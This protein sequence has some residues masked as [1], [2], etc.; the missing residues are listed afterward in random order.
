MQNLMMM[1]ALKAAALLGVLT[2][3]GAVQA[4]PLLKSV[5]GGQG[6]LDTST[7]LEWLQDWNLAGE[8][9]SWSESIA[10]IAKLNADKYAGHND[11]RLPNT[12]ASASSN[13]SL[14]S[15]DPGVGQLYYGYG[16]TGSE[17]GHLFYNVLGGKSDESI[18]TQAGDTADEIANLALFKNVQSHVYWSG[19]EYA[20]GSS[21]A[22][23]FLTYDGRQHVGVK[24]N[25]VYALAV[26][27]GGVTAAVPEPQTWALLL[28]GFTGLLLARR[29][30]AL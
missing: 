23:D 19:T 7:N 6:V 18:L 14:T 1:K 11:W 5:S 9:M 21:L 27:P 2:L 28:M 15:H 25:S 3:V 4:A 26:R 29:R 12:N 22:W 30:R 16:C 17:M 10:W 13:C 8:K 20:P 24:P